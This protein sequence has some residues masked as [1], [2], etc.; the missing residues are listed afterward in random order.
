MERR[1]FRRR[2][3]LEGYDYSRA[4]A[5]FITIVAAQRDLLFLDERFRDA[6]ESC[7]RWLAQ[8]Y[9]YVRLDDYI[10]MPNH[11]HGIVVLD[12]SAIARKTISSLI[13]AYKTVSTKRINA[14]RQTPGSVVWQRSFH[15]RIIRSE[16][17]LNRI[18]QYILDNPTN[19]KDDPENP[20]QRC[21]GTS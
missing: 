8:H 5:Y 9:S 1:R 14:L 18:R 12:E 16:E 7:W 6:A 11:L 4:G 15:D 13:G 2:I 20:A 19:W 21:A 10:V 17:E 3:R